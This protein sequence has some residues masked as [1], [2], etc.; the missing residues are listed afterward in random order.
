MAY[1]V[2]IGHILPAAT[3][4]TV[5]ATLPATGGNLFVQLGI[6]V[7]AGLATWAVLYGLERRRATR[8]R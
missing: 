8:T 3:T 2:S 4:T 7:A 5:V 1:D 6:A